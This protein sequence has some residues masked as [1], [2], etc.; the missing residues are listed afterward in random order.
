MDAGAEC[1]FRYQ[2]DGWSKPYR[3]VGLR[4]EKPRE[5]REAEGAE[6]YQLFEPS[7]YKYRVFVA[8]MN[9]PIRFVVWFCGQR[10]VAVASLGAVVGDGFGGFSALALICAGAAAVSAVVGFATLGGAQ[11]E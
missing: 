6:K 3:F 8:D 7:H 11:S 9:A 5:E 1:E 10:G 2:P 4:S